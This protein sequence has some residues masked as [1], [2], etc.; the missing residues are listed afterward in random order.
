LEKARGTQ[1]AVVQ[2]FPQN[3]LDGKVGNQAS[4]AKV[5]GV[6]ISVQNRLDGKVGNKASVVLNNAKM[7][8]TRGTGG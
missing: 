6:Q 8:P 7:L 3:R 2:N 5:M 1:D 4:D